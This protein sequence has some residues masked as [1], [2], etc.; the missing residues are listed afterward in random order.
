MS[1]TNND[2]QWKEMAENGCFC[3]LVPSMSERFYNVQSK[4]T[5][6]SIMVYE[7]LKD[8]HREKL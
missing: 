2:F 5:P 3:F 8:T 4:L 1:H 6:T 7:A